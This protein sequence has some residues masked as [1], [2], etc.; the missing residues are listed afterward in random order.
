MGAPEG[1]CH[2]PVRPVADGADGY[3]LGH[4]DACLVVDNRRVYTFKGEVAVVDDSVVV[5]AV[6][7]C[8]PLFDGEMGHVL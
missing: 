7:V 8:I 5:P 1:E 3:V 6:G 2:L 4:H